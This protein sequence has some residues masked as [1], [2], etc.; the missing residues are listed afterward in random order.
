MPHRRQRGAPA[1]MPKLAADE[2]LRGKTETLATPIKRPFT[3]VSKPKYHRTTLITV[4][5]S[6][7]P[8]VPGYVRILQG[9]YSCYYYAEIRQCRV[10]AGIPKTC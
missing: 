3:C 10:S 9:V 4:V 5:S 2:G 1:F 6:T 8:S 7:R